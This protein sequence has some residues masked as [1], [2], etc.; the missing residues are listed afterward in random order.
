MNTN[1]TEYMTVREARE[2]LGVTKTK[3][4]ALLKD[5]RLTHRTSEL[6]QRIKLIPRA[7]VE[8]LARANPLPKRAPAAAA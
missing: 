7:E 3:I 2:Y 8:A 4:A 6:N 5:G 1:D